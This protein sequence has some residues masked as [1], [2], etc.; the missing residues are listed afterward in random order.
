MQTVKGAH[1]GKRSRYYDSV[2]TLNALEV[3]DTYDQ[4]PETYVIFVCDFD[5]FW[6]NR[7]VYSFCNR[8]AKN[9]DLLLGDGSYKI[10]LNAYG[11]TS[12]CTREQ[13]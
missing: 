10:L 1:L 8:D 5:P 4:L 12:D 13:K 7:A 3:G 9:P 11:D 6:E 2:M